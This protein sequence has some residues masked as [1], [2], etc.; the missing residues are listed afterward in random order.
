MCILQAAAEPVN[1]WTMDSIQLALVYDPE[2]TMA[3]GSFEEF[4]MCLFG[5]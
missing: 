5:R 2:N 1:C 4:A 3:K